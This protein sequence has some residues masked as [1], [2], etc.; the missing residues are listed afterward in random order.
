MSL[1]YVA[2]FL[3][4]HLSGKDHPTAA[5][6]Q[7]ILSSIGADVDVAVVNKLIKEMEGKEV[8]EV[9]AAGMSKMQSLSLG[10]GGAA[11]A[12]AAAGRAE[13]FDNL[14]K[15]QSAH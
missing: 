1:K 7:S 14:Y 10:G 3:M 6:V 2:A 4:A 13:T 12:A 11:P 8:H 15:T 9:V 5:D